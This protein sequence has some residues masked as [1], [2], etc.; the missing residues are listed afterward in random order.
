MVLQS[1]M[2]L[3]L[4]HLL[5]LV[6]LTHILL[7]AR[8]KVASDASFRVHILDGPL[9]LQVILP[10]LVTRDTLRLLRMS[11]PLLDL[12][13]LLAVESACLG[14]HVLSQHVP[15]DLLLGLLIVAL[16]V[17]TL[18]GRIKIEMFALGILFGRLLKARTINGHLRSV[19]KVVHEEA[20]RRMQLL[21]QRQPILQGLI[22]R[23][24]TEWLSN[25][26]S[27][28]SLRHILPLI[29]VHF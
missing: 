26:R 24:N 4:P 11:L 28:I 16:A 8:C 20:L 3:G 9:V 6:E 5:L 1:S 14:R 7:L 21:P 18:I 23:L 13:A 12:L 10:L 27:L 17:L 25:G 2:R 22:V 19:M 29:V 15:L